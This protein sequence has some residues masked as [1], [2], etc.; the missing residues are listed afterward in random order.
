MDYYETSP[1]DDPPGASGGLVPGVSRRLLVRPRVCHSGVFPLLERR[2]L[3]LR[4][5]RLPRRE[6]SFLSMN[7][8]V[9]R[10][11][12]QAVSEAD[13]PEEAIRLRS[14]RLSDLLPS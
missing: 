5:P 13:R 8:S 4:V 14:K 3:P 10:D 1:L 12:A 7:G 2:W 9:Q 6:N 11:F